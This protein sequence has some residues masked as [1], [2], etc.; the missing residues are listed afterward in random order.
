MRHAGGE[1]PLD[2]DDELAAGRISIQAITPPEHAGRDQ[3]A[4][5]QLRGT[6]AFQPFEKEYVH[7]DGRRVPVLVGAAI[8]PS[9]LYQD[10]DLTPARRPHQLGDAM[11]ARVASVLAP[12]AGLLSSMG[13]T[14]ED[15]PLFFAVAIAAGTFAAV[16]GAGR[17]DT[18]QR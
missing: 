4:L 16:S 5:E 8:D 9:L 12:M 18:L 14:P 11:L 2:G 13:R 17:A 1:Q 3:V 7:R 10:A 15:D 6:G